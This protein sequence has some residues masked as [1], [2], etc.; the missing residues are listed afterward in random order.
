[1]HKGALDSVIDV[2]VAQGYDA[3]AHTG[4]IGTFSLVPQVVDIAGDVPVVAAGGVATGRHVAAALAMGAEGAR[5]GTAW[6]A[7]RSTRCRRPR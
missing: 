2:L 6:L 5:L 7:T 3:G 4:S 1:M